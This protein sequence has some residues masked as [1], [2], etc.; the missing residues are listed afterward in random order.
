MK[1]GR[2]HRPRCLN[3]HCPRQRR[4]THAV[5]DKCWDILPKSWREAIP[6]D[7]HHGLHVGV[8]PP[9]PTWPQTEKQLWELR[10]S[11]FF[12]LTELPMQGTPCKKQQYDPE[13]QSFEQKLMKRLMQELEEIQDPQAGIIV[14]EK[15][16][17]ILLE[18]FRMEAAE[19]V[20]DEIT[21]LTLN[22]NKAV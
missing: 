8:A 4:P 9:S 19:P 21:I 6:K 16:R 5:C 18:S 20:R 3:P 2:K 14:C 13:H 12:H 1:Y 15:M 11:R 22:I 7:K 10:I 17:D